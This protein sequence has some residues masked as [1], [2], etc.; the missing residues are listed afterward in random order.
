MSVVY[1]LLACLLL[2]MLMLP[3]VGVSVDVVDV[4]V[5]SGGLID[6]KRSEVTMK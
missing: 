4:F 3:G 2:L 6:E 5:S 1:L